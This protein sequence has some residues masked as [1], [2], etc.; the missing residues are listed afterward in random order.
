MKPEEQLNMLRKIWGRN[1]RGYVFLPW[2]AAEHAASTHRKQMWQEGKAFYWPRDKTQIINHLYEHVEDELY[3]SV[4]MFA[5]SVRR[6][7][8]VLVTKCLYA[9]LDEVDPKTIPD[10]YRPTHAWQTSPGRYAA[11]WEMVEYRREATEAGMENHKLTMFVGAD[12][13]GWDTT[14]LLRVPGSVNNKAE[15]I[16][17]NGH[18]VRGKLIWTD[19]EIHGW[20]KMEELPEVDIPDAVNV[21]RLSEE[22][23]ESVD[24]HAV[25]AKVRLKVS[26]V[27]RSYMRMREV[28]DLDRSDVLWQINCDLAQ[29]GCSLAEIVAITRASVW[30]KYE[31]RQD[32]LKRLF[33]EASKALGEK[34]RLTENGFEPLEAEEGTEKPNITQLKPFWEDESYLNA[35]EPEWLVEGFI[36]KGGCGFISGAPKSLK[37]WL[38]LDLAISTSVGIPFLDYQST[39]PINVMY[40]QQEDHASTVL[41]RHM[42]IANS[43]A[44]QHAPGDTLTP[45]QGALYMIVQKG[46]TGT[47]PGWQA[48]LSEAVEELKIELVIFDTLSTISNGIDIDKAGEVKRQLLDPVKVIARTHDCAMLFVHHNTK[49]GANT[50]A[51]QNMAGSGQIHAWADMGIYIMD[52]TNDNKITFDLETKFTQT[53]KLIYHLD[54]LEDNPKRWIPREVLKDEAAGSGRTDDIHTAKAPAKAIRTADQRSTD[55][56]KTTINK[57]IV[58]NL[59]RQGHNTYASLRAHPEV[60]HISDTSLRR[61]MTGFKS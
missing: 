28:G 41:E 59:M 13:S 47:D 12:P 30:N 33:T 7:D 25:W 42:I 49:S 61:Y 46:Y 38:G 3:F 23:L 29:A 37:S 60:K 32:E 35:P 21:D 22:L 52:K 44:P 50:R 10:F 18:P 39:R 55:R 53:V 6:A 1:R 20:D 16:K 14:Q 34:Q 51:G 57:P 27:V 40:I 17:A 15:V 9:D 43:K 36:P 24:R 45:S 48:W 31:G 58:H 4:Q 11:A 19:R 8:E 26:S 56:Q 54:G 2:I 5:T